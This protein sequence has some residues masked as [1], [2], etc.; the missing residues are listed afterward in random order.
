MTQV[1][2]VGALGPDDFFDWDQVRVVDGGGNAVAQPSPINVTSNL[3]RTG[4]ISDGG[5]FTGLVEGTDWFGNFTVGNGAAIRPPSSS[6]SSA[7]HDSG[8]GVAEPKI[9]TAPSSDARFAATVR[10]S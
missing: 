7:S 6:R 3:A 1:G 10:A 8:R 9:A 5:T 4:S 2:S